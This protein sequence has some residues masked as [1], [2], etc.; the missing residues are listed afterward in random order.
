M[1]WDKALKVG[2]VERYSYGLS[3]WTNGEQ[4]ETASITCSNQF[5]T[6][7]AVSIDNNAQLISFLATGVAVGTQQL[8]VNFSTLTRSDTSPL[9]K[10]KVIALPVPQ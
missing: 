10:I 1:A 7:S 2:K 5:A 8:R 6:I 9:M 4:I 3:E